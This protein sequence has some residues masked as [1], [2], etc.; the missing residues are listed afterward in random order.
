MSFFPGQDPAA[1]DKLACD[2]IERMIVPRTTD[3]SGFEISQAFTVGAALHGRGPFVFL[4]HMD[5]AEF[6]AGTGLDVRPHPHIGL[7]AVTYLFDGEIQ[8]RDGLGNVC[9]HSTWRGQLDDGWARHR[10]FGTHGLPSG[11]LPAINCMVCNVGWHCRRTRKKSSHPA[12]IVTPS[13]YR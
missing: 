2:A 6:R 3:L 5:P 13:I 4:D 7:A 11:A 10:A 9:R 12:F 1:G 8:H